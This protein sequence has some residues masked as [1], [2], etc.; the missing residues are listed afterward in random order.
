[1]RKHADQRTIRNNIHNKANDVE[2]MVL[3]SQ[4]RPEPCQRPL[5]D[6]TP[7]QGG[8][9]CALLVYCLTALRATLCGGSTRHNW[10]SV[11]VHR[12]RSLDTFRRVR[13]TDSCSSFVIM[14][15]QCLLTFR[16]ARMVQ[17]LRFQTV[18]FHF[19]R[20]TKATVD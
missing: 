14:L 20:P 7:T 12:I 10:K 2:T 3:H 4:K 5:C 16:V 6:Q 11:R 9:E 15:P 17:F 19:S 8:Y 1:M 13:Y 18:N